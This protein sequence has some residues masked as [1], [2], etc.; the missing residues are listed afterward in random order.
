LIVIR[1]ETPGAAAMPS[2]ASAMIAGAAQ[3][4]F[5]PAHRIAYAVRHLTTAKVPEQ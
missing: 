1:L 4:A 3:R 2:S 5:D